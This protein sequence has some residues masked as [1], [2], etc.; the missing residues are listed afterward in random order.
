M[1][2]PEGIVDEKPNVVK[3]TLI[4]FFVIMILL[5]LIMLTMGGKLT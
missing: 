2:H 5:I 3:N 4:S 1:E